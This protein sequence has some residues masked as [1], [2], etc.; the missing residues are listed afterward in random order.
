MRTDRLSRRFDDEALARRKNAVL[1]R[2]SI[3]AVIER[4]VV[5]GKRS[6]ASRQ[7]LCPFHQEKTG[8]FTVYGPRPGRAHGIFTCFGCGAK[9]HVIDF[10]MLRQGVGYREAIELLEAESGLRSLQRATPARAPTVPQLADDAAKVRRALRIFAEA[11]PIEKGDPVDLYLRGRALV[12]PAEYGI[13]EPGVNGGWPADLRFAPRC[14]HYQAKQNFG[15][16]LA[17]IRAH[18]GTHL[19]THCTYLAPRG[20]GWGKVVLP[21]GMKGKLVVCSYG[22]GFI[23][24]G[25]DADAMVGGEGIETSLSAMQLYRRSGLAFVT[26]GRMKNTEPPFAC[27]DFIWAADKGG[28]NG[29]RWGEVFALAGAAAFGTGRTVAVKIPKLEAAK[30]DFNDLLQLRARQREAAAA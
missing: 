18:D 21:A 27:S 2:V 19:T 28:G 23:R 16:L 5:L 9:G 15:A 25:P 4:V 6:G 13:G 22:P 10:V 14:W 30:G 29:T 1:E 17:A 26:S 8:S 24:L 20:A 7:G 3:E 11:Q 12:P